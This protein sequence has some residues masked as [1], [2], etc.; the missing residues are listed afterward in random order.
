MCRCKGKTGRVD[1]E[2]CYHPA[3]PN[4]MMLF[5]NRVLIS[6]AAE[7]GLVIEPPQPLQFLPYIGVA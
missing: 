5:E 6:A 4:A 1:A 3:I 2:E 7:M